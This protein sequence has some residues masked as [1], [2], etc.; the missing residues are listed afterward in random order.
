[1]N[2]SAN[3]KFEA[4]GRVRDF[5]TARTADFA[6]TSLAIQLLTNLSSSI[7]RLEGLSAT[8]QSG[9]GAAR[10]GT[11]TRGDARDE[12][13]ARMKAI[14]RTAQ[15]I[16]IDTPGLD[17][18]F[19]TPRGDNDQTLIAAARGFAA[20]AAPLTAQFVAHEMSATFIDDLNASIAR[21]ETAI[22]SQS[23]AVGDRVGARAAIEDILDEC[24]N[25]V[26]KLDP[27]VRNK[28]A[29]DPATL[30]EWTSAS[31]VERAPKHK[32]TA[33]VPNAP[34]GANTPPAS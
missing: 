4:C 33:P 7:A 25:I 32:S 3:R 27:I 10:E 24:M 9:G 15:A 28:Y 5:G 30:A 18:K 8:Q 16:A 21:F 22:S 17:E 13:H 23:S 12:L 14:S 34:V 19:R 31:H 11:A 29:N 20:D 2:D 6:P 26:R 1:M